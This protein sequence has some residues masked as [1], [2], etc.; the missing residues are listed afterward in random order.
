MKKKP[1]GEEKKGKE[2]RRCTWLKTPKETKERNIMQI[3]KTNRSKEL[4]CGKEEWKQEK[5]NMLY[6]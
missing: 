6:N 1:T 2:D 5:K 4:E 3:E